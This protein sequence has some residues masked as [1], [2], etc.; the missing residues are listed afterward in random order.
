MSYGYVTA[1]GDCSHEIKGYLLL[2]RKAM[3]NLESILKS[4]DIALST[5]LFQE[6]YVDM[7]VGPWRRLN[8]E[9]LMLLNCGGGEDYWQS[10][11]Q[12]GDQASQPQGNQPWIFIGR[13]DAET[14]T[15]IFW[16]PDAKGWLI[17]KDPDAGKDWRQKEK[18]MTEDK[19]VGWHHRFNGH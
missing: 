10:L 4:R 7:R 13:T 1:G 3:T 11:G 8:T 17:R 12:K 5:L 6:S 9:E 2:G 14:E 19:M 15:P 16:P 18:G